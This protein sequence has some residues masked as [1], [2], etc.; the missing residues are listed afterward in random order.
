M[1]QTLAKLGGD[2]AAIRP[3]LTLEADADA[4]TKAC[5]LV[6]EA[7][8]RL[9]SSGFLIEATRLVAHALPKREAVWWACMCA[10]HTA[11]VDLPDADR[12]CREAAEDW[13]RQQAETSR[14]VAFDLAQA[15]GFRTPEAWAAMAAFWSGGSMAPEGQPAVP[16]APH[17]SGTAVAG[18]VALAA[19][20]G[21]V[22][23]RDARLHQFLESGRNIATGG[24]G[25]LPAETG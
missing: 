11:P 18:S 8:D 13:V 17:L 1:S 20:R 14:R 22:A 15:G 12:K 16:P 4:V 10:I 25:R 5:T 6:P 2:L 3:H 7:L 24:P 21:D 9:T 23:R 19:V